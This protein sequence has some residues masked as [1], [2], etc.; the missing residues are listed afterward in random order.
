MPDREE[1][2]RTRPDDDAAA[3]EQG[4]GATP[5]ADA[6]TRANEAA[7]ADAEG[8]A[9]D[10][11]QSNAVRELDRSRAD[12]G[13]YVLD[14]EA[15]EGTDDAGVPDRE[16]PAATAPERPERGPDREPDAPP[17]TPPGA[18]AT[19]AAERPA[20]ERVAGAARAT[21]PPTNDRRRHAVD[22]AGHVVDY[23]FFLLYGVLAIRFILTLMGASES[24]GF[25]RIIHAVSDPFYAPFR[26]LAASPAAVQAA[27]FSLIAALLAYLLLHVAVRGLLRLLAGGRAR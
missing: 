6:D 22:R 2:R 17:A 23:L 3:E 25:V 10:A 20:P 19:P 26:G 7:A 14:P 9:S 11:E 1:P 24:A 16:P 27:D 5:S 4:G 13:P 12:R 15:G 21:P 18:A 8:A